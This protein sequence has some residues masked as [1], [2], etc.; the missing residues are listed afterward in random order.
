MVR[1]RTTGLHNRNSAS[2]MWHMSQIKSIGL[3]SQAV[4]NTWTIPERRTSQANVTFTV[5]ER[6][7]HTVR[8]G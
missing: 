3:H 1:W 6:V 5:P 4:Q 7:T 2:I 8:Y